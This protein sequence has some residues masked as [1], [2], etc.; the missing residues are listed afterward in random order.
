MSKKDYFAGIEA[1]GTKFVCVI[2]NNPYDILAEIEFPTTRPEE[3]INK[4]IEF[5]SFQKREHKIEINAFGIGCF[6]PVDLNPDSLTYGSIT[7]TPKEYWSNQ[8]IIAPIQSVFPVPI[9]FDTD[10]NAAAIGEG[11]WGAARQFKN[12]IYITIGTGIG[13]GIIIDSQPVHGL[14]HPEVGHMLLQQDKIRDPYP[15]HCPFHSNCFEGLA[16][17]LSLEDRWGIIPVK[18][19]PDHPAW[20]LEVEYICQALHNLICVYSPEA[21]I[22]GGGVMQQHHLFGKIRAKTKSSLNDY[23][24]SDRIIN[25]IDQYIL[26]PGLGKR[27]GAFGAL[28]MAQKLIN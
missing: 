5:F 8:N 11:K 12:Y 4:V 6:G 10:V 24:Q 20:D 27:S 26:P 18:L 23:L 25:Q 9:A 14:I 7:L 16:S 19:P 13:A 1:G 2:G 3:T 21:I 17:G 28:A 22:L 15:G